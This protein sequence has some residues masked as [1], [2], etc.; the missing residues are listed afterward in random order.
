MASSST[1]IVYAHAPPLEGERDAEATV[2]T[3]GSHQGDGDTNDLSYTRR[4]GVLR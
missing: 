1:E 4:D 2:G 3:N